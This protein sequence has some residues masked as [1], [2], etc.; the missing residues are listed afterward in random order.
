MIQQENARVRQVIRIDKLPQRLARPPQGN[1]G[2]IAALC[3]PVFH[4][5][6]G[7][8]MAVPGIEIVPDAVGVGGNGGDKVHPIL[9]MQIAAQPLAANLCQGI[10]LVGDFGQSG[11][12]HFLLH[13][14]GALLGVHAGATQK[15]EF[16][17][18]VLKGRPDEILL[19]LHILIEK[20]CGCLAVCPDAPYF[21]GGIDHIFRLLL[22]KKGLYR[23]LI[24][25]IQLPMGPQNQIMVSL[26]PELSHKRA[27]HQAGMTGYIN[28]RILIHHGLISGSHSGTFQCSQ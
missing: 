12:Q 3:L 15:Q 4:Q 21:R 27:A 10:A 20:V 8:H 17:Y 16:F 26:L 25:Q 11:E 5:Q 28:F 13:G 23:C 14:L 19:H 22:G 7:N 18:M 2:G 6:G 24:Q 9:L 1:T